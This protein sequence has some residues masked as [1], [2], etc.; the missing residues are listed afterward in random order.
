[1]VQR[2]RFKPAPE[3][4]GPRGYSPSSVAELR[5]M[6]ASGWP[7]VNREK[8][9]RLVAE[10]G[11]ESVDPYEAVCGLAGCSSQ[12][13][14]LLRTD[15]R[16]SGPCRRL[17]ERAQGMLD[18]LGR[19]Y[20]G[21]FPGA[22]HRRVLRLVALLKHIDAP[23]CA[24]DGSNLDRAERRVAEN[25]L[26]VLTTDWITPA[27]LKAIRLL[28]TQDIIGA[29][30]Q[31][32]VDYRE[33]AAL[34]AGWPSPLRSEGDD[35]ALAA[36][37]A[38]AS[39][40]E[41]S[42]FYRDA[43]TLELRPCGE[44]QSWLFEPGTTGRLMPRVPEHREIVRRLLVKLGAM[45]SLVPPS[46]E[47]TS[48]EV[49]G[50]VSFEVVASAQAWSAEL[51]LEWERFVD[52]KRNLTRFAQEHGLP[53]AGLVRTRSGRVSS[54]T[55]VRHPGETVWTPERCERAVEELAAGYGWRRVKRAPPPRSVTVALGLRD[56]AR[57]RPAYEALARLL[58][59]G[60]EWRTAESRLVFALCVGGGV[61]WR[62][63]PGIVIDASRK[64]LPAV[65]RVALELGQRRYLLTDSQAG[66]TQVRALKEPA[67]E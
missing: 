32:D 65:E 53:L 3:L 56:G 42:R 13:A 21:L 24:A 49:A 38:D 7:L 39:V 66:H 1:M 9:N 20:I 59:H 14:A 6:L 11:R 52:L 67:D 46:P 60:S 29:A 54:L 30:I 16:S 58:A 48:R 27:E 33:P 15:F 40:R 57:R 51:A 36:Y 25:L 23:L 28:L 17:H 37:L 64:D 45:A 63:E 61:V 43:E 2:Q 31:G 62:D 47:L 5:R 41:P 10:L 4:V 35:L 12:M 26:A 50:A 18:A 19:D 44:T 34:R 8:F 55:L 22:M